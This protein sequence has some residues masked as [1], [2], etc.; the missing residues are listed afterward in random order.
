VEGLRGFL[1]RISGASVPSPAWVAC[2]HGGSSALWEER[3]L[4]CV[5]RHGDCL[6]RVEG[7]EGITLGS[8][9]SPGVLPAWKGQEVSSVTYSAS[10]CRPGR[11]EGGRGAACGWCLQE[12]ARRFPATG[13]ARQDVTN[14]TSTRLT[15]ISQVSGA[16]EY[17]QLFHVEHLLNLAAFTSSS[18]GAPSGRVESV[19]R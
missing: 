10:D 8:A 19:K 13:V 11:V 9:N 1:G 7:E 12:V 18:A 6:V 3:V 15:R 14:A 17:R 5:G 2:G 4:G 16:A